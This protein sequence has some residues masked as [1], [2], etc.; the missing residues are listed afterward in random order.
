[1]VYRREI[2]FVPTSS[3]TLFG[4]KG[5]SITGDSLVGPITQSCSEKCSLRCS[6]IGCR[7]W[8]TS[9]TVFDTNSGYSYLSE[10]G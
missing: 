6:I 3:R 9:K 5:A 7:H 4:T 8:T 2:T 1:M 10:I